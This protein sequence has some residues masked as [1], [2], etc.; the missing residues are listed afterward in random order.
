MRKE[1][2]SFFNLSS[3]HKHNTSDIIRIHLIMEILTFHLKWEANWN[4]GTRDEWNTVGKHT[5]NMQIMG[6]AD[7]VKKG[8]P[9]GR[10]SDKSAEH[11]GG[12]KTRSSSLWALPCSCQRSSVRLHLL[13]PTVYSG[14]SY[15]YQHPLSTQVEN[16]THQRPLST[17]VRT[18]L[19]NALCFL[20]WELCCCQLRWQLHII[21]ACCWLWWKLHLPTPAVNSGDL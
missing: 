13:V 17:Q 7:T 3:R 16:S 15:T 21:N 19:T 4:L 12:L 18:S 2:I 8:V 14:E 5:N 6:R 1:P 20:R 11:R 10:P 9:A